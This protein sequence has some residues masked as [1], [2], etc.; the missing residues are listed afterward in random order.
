MKRPMSYLLLSF[1]VFLFLGKITLLDYCLS[2]AFDIHS[3]IQSEKVDE[4]EIIGEFF[5]FFEEAFS[6]HSFVPIESKITKAHKN[7]WQDI[8]LSVT[9]PPPKKGIPSI[10]KS[11]SET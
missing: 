6:T 9:T 5:L 2:K 3:T 4:T 1:G 8:V 10:D 11:F 7:R